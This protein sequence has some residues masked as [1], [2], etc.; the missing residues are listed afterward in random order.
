MDVVHSFLRLLFLLCA[1]RLVIFK[2]MRN[3]FVLIAYLDPC[4]KS[5]IYDSRARAIVVMRNMFAL[6]SHHGQSYRHIH[7]CRDPILEEVV[8]CKFEIPHERDAYPRRIRKCVP[9]SSSSHGTKRALHIHLHPILSFRLFSRSTRMVR[10]PSDSFFFVV[11][12]CV[13][14]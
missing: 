11:L 8:G 13:H 2:R 6:H 1:M 3:F 10:R 4:V 9:T 7:R 5:S 12:A 14:M